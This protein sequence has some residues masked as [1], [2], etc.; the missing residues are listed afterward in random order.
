MAQA[1]TSLIWSPRSNISLYGDTA[2]VTEAARLGVRIAL[3]TDWLASGSMNVLRELRCA[4]S[5]NQ[6]YYGKFFSDHDLWMMTTGNAA[7]ATA[8]DDVIG[9]LE[10]GKIGDV[11]IFDGTTHKDYRA[12]IDAEP[13]DVQL[14]LRAGKT[15][16]GDDALVAAIPASGSC[17]PVN[18]CSSQKRVC[19]QGEIGKTYSALQASANIYEA[20][21]CGTPSNEPSCKPVRP[22][23]VN[24]STVYTGEVTATDSDGDGIA[25]ATD[26]CKNTFNPIRPMDGGKQADA[27]NDSV[28]DACDPC[29][30][31][32][33]TSVCTA[34][35]PNDSDGDTID[36]AVDNCPGAANTDQLDADQDGK[37]DACDPCPNAPNPGASACPATIYQI[38]D[39]TLPAGS[40][41]ALTNQLVTGPHH[42]GLLPAGEER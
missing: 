35:N 37:G 28:G 40:T 1:H 38:K 10:A 34:F 23:S 36:N 15:L 16:Y 14:V 17:D 2:I 18:V 19:L 33:N 22:T 21:F 7:A 11:S 29:P 26:N 30:L 39:G 42:Q 20:F 9:R 6:T 12:I 13:Q 3:G 41:V 27:D 5:L 25:D 31:D 4:D 24:G 8:V 32:A